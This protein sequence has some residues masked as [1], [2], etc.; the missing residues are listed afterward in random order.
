ML[1]V[2]EAETAI[3]EF[4]T[5]KKPLPFHIRRLIRD[6]QEFLPAAA[7]V[8]RELSLHI[9]S[10]NRNN[11]ICVFHQHRRHT[12]ISD[13]VIPG[14][15]HILRGVPYSRIVGSAKGESQPPPEGFLHC[16]CS[17]DVA[18][19]DFFWWKTWVLRSARQD[20]PVSEGMGEEVIAPRVRAFFAQ[21]FTEATGLTIDELY[22]TH[23]G[24]HGFN[25]KY[26]RMFQ[27][28][29]MLDLVN[30]FNARDGSPLL[31]VGVTVADPNDEM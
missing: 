24:I 14:Q 15:K 28:K 2:V 27:L 5:K 1:R 18:L 16:G 30:E 3:D 23:A 26:V 20:L 10:T 8:S 4:L 17:I 6:V 19:L 7:T 29:K 25:S 12:K 21:G 31:T 22:A 9:L 13:G 11:S